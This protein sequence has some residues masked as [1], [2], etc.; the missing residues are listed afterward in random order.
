MTGYK[1]FPYAARQGGRWWVLRMNYDF[2]EHDLYTV[3]IDGTAT[4]DVSGN[5]HSQVPLI[6]SVGLLQP[7]A[8]A[9]DRPLMPVD[10]AEA[11][12]RPCT[13]FL[14]YGS[15]I[16]DPCDW[17]EHLADR[18]PFELRPGIRQSPR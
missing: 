5:R 16:G 3:F 6:A 13:P 7:C 17:C 8:P 18:D 14:V 12:V 11:V 2:P 9:P 1:F 15:E 4:A 10:E